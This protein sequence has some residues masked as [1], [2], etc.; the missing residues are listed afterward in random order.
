ME[1]A[2]LEEKMAQKKYVNEK[3]GTKNESRHADRFTTLLATKISDL[4]QKSDWSQ[5]LE[6]GAPGSGKE[7]VYD[8]SSDSE[9]D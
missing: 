1:M 5:L 4:V 9:S 7:T 6:G 3:T 8:D 2:E